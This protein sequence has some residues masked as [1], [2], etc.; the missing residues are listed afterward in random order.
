M[1]RY[2]VKPLLKLVMHRFFGEASGFVDMIVQNVP[3]PVEAA[4]SKV[5]LGWDWRRY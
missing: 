4:A 3:S 1:C 2:D 5:G